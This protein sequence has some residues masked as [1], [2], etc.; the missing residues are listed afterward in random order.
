MERHVRIVGNIFI[1]KGF[2]SFFWVV[3]SVAFVPHL[4]FF[5]FL[6]IP[7]ILVGVALKR[8]RAWARSAAICLA[9]MNLPYLP[10]G[11]A[12]SI[13]MLWVLLSR[14]T[15]RLFAE[16]VFSHRSELPVHVSRVDT[17]ALRCP[18]CREVVKR[19]EA[20][21]ICSSCH[22]THHEECWQL[23]GARCTTFGCESR[24]FEVVPA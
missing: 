4:P 16:E 21:R 18:Y 8:H 15:N 22:T 13:Y 17:E 7:N 12:I 24:K 5:F 2:L 20:Q 23:N 9:A 3:F 6:V 10:L 14:Q 11:T 1:A 19:H